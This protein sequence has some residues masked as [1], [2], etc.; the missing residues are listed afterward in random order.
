MTR[1]FADWNAPLGVTGLRADPSGV[2]DTSTVFQATLFPG[3]C[4]VPLRARY[5]CLIAAARYY[6]VRAGE[7]VESKLPLLEHLRR[8][9]AL[10]AVCTV[11]HH[12]DEGFVPTGI[13]GR[14]AAM[15]MSQQP[16][17]VLRTGLKRHPYNIYQVTLATLYILHTSRSSD[18]FY[19]VPQPLAK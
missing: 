13:I 7:A 16:E 10:I 19:D 11:L 2:L 9:E 18:P 12:Q 15:D 14:D 3:M 17:I 4:T 1:L 8:L 5:I 6:R